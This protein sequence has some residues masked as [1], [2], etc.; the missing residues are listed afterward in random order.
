VPKANEKYWTQLPLQPIDYFWKRS[1][2]LDAE[3]AF[4]DEDCD[5]ELDEKVGADWPDRLEK[6][7]DKV[8]G[9]LKDRVFYLVGEEDNQFKTANSDMFIEL[10]K[11]I[12]TAEKYYFE[13]KRASLLAT[14]PAGYSGQFE[15]RSRKWRPLC[16]T[17]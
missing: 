13:K 5:E 11:I 15:N 3:D 12:G 4:K 8:S 6:H 2:L 10:C 9:Y 14:S 7:L 16:G 1:L 17:H